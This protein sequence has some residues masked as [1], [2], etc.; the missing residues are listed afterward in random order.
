[1]IT[2]DI[3]EKSILQYVFF[4]DSKVASRGYKFQALQRY[5]HSY[6]IVS[7]VVTIS[8]IMGVGNYLIKKQ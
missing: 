3:S 2:N 7:S 6:P 1:M 5:Y 8:T 4:M